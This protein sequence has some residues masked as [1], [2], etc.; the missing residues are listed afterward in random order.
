[1]R[2]RRSLWW[3]R[4]LLRL[5]W[6]IRWNERQ[7]D[8]DGDRALLGRAAARQW[9]A[10]D[11]PRVGGAIPDSSGTIGGRRLLAGGHVRQP[12]ATHPRRWL[13]V[14]RHTVHRTWPFLRPKRRSEHGPDQNH[15]Q[16]KTHP[17]L[18][19]DSH[20]V[21]A[22]LRINAG[23]VPANCP[24]PYRSTRRVTTCYRTMPERLSL[25]VHGMRR[26][27]PATGNSGL[28]R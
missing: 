9:I 21:P 13:G 11:H 5:R 6:R 7:W 4:R 28:S 22:T 10:E 27:R 20:R 1:M 8:P 15:R 12:D 14:G 2:G 17:E 3:G 23:E 16:D 19:R 18:P 26:N 25:A 24:N